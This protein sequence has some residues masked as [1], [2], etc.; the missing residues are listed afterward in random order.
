L[1]VVDPVP[2]E[3]TKKSTTTSSK[4][5]SKK[6][7]NFIHSYRVVN[8][9]PILINYS[10]VWYVALFFFCSLLSHCIVDYSFFSS[11]LFKII[12][13]WINQIFI[14]SSYYWL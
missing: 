13:A 7:C 4:K 1:V 10:S 11:S 2:E 6:W 12:I 5:H 8:S 3:K 14:R 9:S